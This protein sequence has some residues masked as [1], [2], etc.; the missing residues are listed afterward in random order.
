MDQCDAVFILSRASQF[1]TEEDII[2]SKRTL[3]GCG[4]RHQVLVATQMDLSAQN[5]VGKIQ[6]YKE[7]FQRSMQ[8]VRKS[9]SLHDLHLEPVCISAFMYACA[10]KMKNN[11]SLDDEER[12]LQENIAQFSRDTPDTEEEFRRFSNMIAIYKQLKS[13][14]QEKDQIILEH[15]RNRMNEA[16]R[17]VLTILNSLRT[18]VDK[19][20]RLL[21]ENDINTLQKKHGQIREAMDSVSAQISD[22][23]LEMENNVKNELA[24]LR[25]R[26]LANSQ[27]FDEIHVEKHTEQKNHSHTTGFI[28]KKTIYTT[29]TI[30]KFSADLSEALK[31]IKDFVS[32]IEK[33]INDTFK[34]LLNKDSITNSIKKTILPVF[35]V[36]DISFDENIVILPVR[37]VVHSINAPEFKFDNTP[38][39]GA[40]VGEFSD[41]ILNDRVSAF[42]VA[43]QQQMQKLCMD[44]RNK[45]DLQRE[46]ISSLLF[47]QS[48]GFSLKLISSLDEQ[49]AKIQDQM[50]NREESLR[51]Y[52]EAKALLLQS[53]DKMAR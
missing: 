52:D 21:R 39:N 25:Q 11:L 3:A 49:M 33:D 48:S 7:A 19:D 42:K 30:T 47:R 8:R 28:W 6:S 29:E 53:Y 18:G 37:E 45:L 2:L 16:H 24:A 15:Q 43:F 40:L 1:L 13:W 32:H 17:E 23:F 44:I 51:R 14:R 9:S 31:Q 36:L 46:E 41:G 22:L 12:K 20:K 27:Q 34:A 35:R 4:I 26:V 38:Y 10:Y 5:E 50:T